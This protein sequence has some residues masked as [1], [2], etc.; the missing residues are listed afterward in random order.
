MRSLVERLQAGWRQL[1]SRVQTRRQ[2]DNQVENDSLEQ[3]WRAEY[4][5]M[6]AILERK[7]PGRDRRWRPF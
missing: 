7:D 2:V 4:D 5:E 6:V 3:I 1:M